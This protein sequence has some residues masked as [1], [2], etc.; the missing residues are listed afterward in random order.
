M[1]TDVSWVYAHPDFRVFPA[2]NQPIVV[3][4]PSQDC[5]P[6]TNMQMLTVMLKRCGVDI[7]PYCA[8]KLM[9]ID[10]GDL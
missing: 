1:H 4:T 6:M 8:Y 5:M 7:D 9:Y 10:L 3:H 2:D